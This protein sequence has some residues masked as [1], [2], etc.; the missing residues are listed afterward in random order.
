MVFKSA[1]SAMANEWREVAAG[2]E[3]QQ[4]A[5]VERGGTQKN[6]GDCAAGCGAA[7]D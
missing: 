6:C 2:L 7:S 4:T 5:G 3:E 1:L